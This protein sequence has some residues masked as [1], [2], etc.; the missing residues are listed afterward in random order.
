MSTTTQVLMQTA[1]DGKWPV[2]SVGD[3]FDLVLTNMVESGAI[4]GFFTFVRANSRAPAP[5]VGRGGGPPD[6]GSS[7]GGGG[8]GGVGGGVPVHVGPEGDAYLN[9]S[10]STGVPAPIGPGGDVSVPPG[11]VSGIPEYIGPGAE[12]TQ[13]AARA[14]SRLN[15]WARPRSKARRH[16]AQGEHPGAHP[17]SARMRGNTCAR[18]RRPRPGRK[19]PG[20]IVAEATRR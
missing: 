11:T 13:P 2:T 12:P 10:V 6:G 19:V 14:T 8:G 20:R 5:P 16:L 4:N 18:V 15:P 7:G 9:S 17:R 1:I 3:F